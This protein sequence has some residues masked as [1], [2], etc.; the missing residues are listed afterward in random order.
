M[1]ARE[2]ECDKERTSTP[3]GD[4]LREFE[5]YLS[6]EESG[7]S[8]PEPSSDEVVFSLLFQQC[9]DEGTG[10]VEVDKLVQFIRTVQL[11]EQNREGDEVY[12]SQDDLSK[13]QYNLHLLKAMLEC[14]AIEDRVDQ[15]TYSHIIKMWVKDV[16]GRCDKSPL[17]SLPLEVSQL[18]DSGE[19]QQEQERSYTSGS[20]SLEASGGHSSQHSLDRIELI[21]SVADLKLENKRLQERNQQLQIQMEG[22]EENLKD[23]Q[24]QNE[25]LKHD[26][27]NVQANVTHL[28]ELEKDN[29]EL[30]GV[31]AGIRTQCSELSSQVAALEKQLLEANGELSLLQTQLINADVD[32]GEVE[33]ENRALHLLLIQKEEM[34]SHQELKKV[35]LESQLQEIQHHQSELSQTI[36]DLN[37]ANENLRTEN[38]DLQAHH[39]PTRQRPLLSSTPYKS[40]AP[41]WHDELAAQESL[42]NRGSPIQPTS[43]ARRVDSESFSRLLQETN[44]KINHTHNLIVREISDMI[45]QPS[46]LPSR[47]SGE[48]SHTIFSEKFSEKSFHAFESKL[49]EILRQKKQLHNEN[50]ELETQVKDLNSKLQK[51]EEEMQRMGEQEKVVCE[52]MATQACPLTTPTDESG[53]QTDPL[54]VNETSSVS[55]TIPQ[56]LLLHIQSPSTLSAEEHLVRPST[57]SRS[58]IIQDSIEA[59]DFESGPDCVDGVTGED[60]H[61]MEKTL[62]EVH[63]RHDGLTNQFAQ[64][65]A[66]ANW[67]E[68]GRQS[69]WLCYRVLKGVCWVLLL[70]VL[71][72]LLVAGVVLLHDVLDSCGHY[73]PHS[74]LSL[75]YS[76]LDPPLNY[77]R[78]FTAV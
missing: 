4:E 11:G 15:T 14:N 3:Q 71:V 61:M 42:M 57:L 73:C 77:Q 55:P 40:M 18:S 26:I 9:D 75:L 60:G 51:L 70:S 44:V 5:P 31:V 23:I 56:P 17:H 38:A 62:E 63:Q 64:L 35:E 20:N 7:S 10:L 30:A 29:A 54:P 68:R 45:N 47:H 72:M 58:G 46:P 2:V 66:R 67:L 43:P 12:D 78:S 21:S 36:A 32:K 25:K 6:G 74:P 39:S 59:V 28:D 65:E 69:N 16:R 34:L 24:T 13:L 53:V 49:S 52:E 37:E 48:S 27:K 50:M 19:E 76:M 22:S 1:A 8:S 33:E 41:S